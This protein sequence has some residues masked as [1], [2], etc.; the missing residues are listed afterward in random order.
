MPNWVTNTLTIECDDRDYLL[1][2]GARLRAPIPGKDENGIAITRDAEFSF[3]NITKPEDS[4]LDEYFAPADATQLNNPNNWYNWNNRNWGC[5]WDARVHYS[6]TE[7]KMLTYEF[8]TAWAPPIKVLEDL[9]E[10]LPDLKITLRFVEEQGWGGVMVFK[11]GEI[12]E[13]EQWDI[14]ESHEEAI[15]AFGVCYNCD[16]IGNLYQDCPEAIASQSHDRDIELLGECRWC[17]MNE[18]GRY[19]DCP[20]NEEGTG[21]DLP[22]VKKE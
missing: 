18:D 9:C 21:W 6:N 12:Y 14:P 15:N 19:D 3:W 11:E 10:E 17:D 13:L 22:E 4:I 8:D 7:E 2:V 16:D 20:P 5:K 1:G